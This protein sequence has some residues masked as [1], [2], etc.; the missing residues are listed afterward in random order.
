MTRPITVKHLLPLL[1]LPLFF[2]CHPESPEDLLADVRAK[3]A[4]AQSISY[5]LHEIW[6]NRFMGTADTSFSTV[7]LY[8][9]E[10][11]TWDYDYIKESESYD[12]WLIG[13]R[14]GL[15]LHDEG[16]AIVRTEE[17]TMANFQNDAPNFTISSAPDYLLGL[18]DWKFQCDTSFA[19]RM[20]KMYTYRSSFSQEDTVTYQRYEYLFIDP[21]SR[22]VVG[23]RFI[24]FINER[25]N[26]VV[27]FWYEN[28]EEDQLEPLNYVPVRNYAQTT[29]TAY[30]A[31]RT[32]G[33]IT[34]GEPAPDFVAT[35]LSGDTFALKDYR[36]QRL[37]LD[38]SFIGCGGCE[39]AMKE[40]NRPGFKLAD[41]MKGV[42]LSY[43]NKP[44]EISTHYKD[45]GMPFIAIP[46]ARDP[47][48]MY[49][50]YAYPTFVIID[51][52]GKVER[53]EVGFS[54]EFIAS[55]EER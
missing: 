34:V 16:I 4:M 11:P 10:K 27:S 28:Y 2:A 5:E 46:E 29:Q 25:T 21:E 53:V 1:F 30:D 43:M 6:D 48:R 42:Y 54:E 47:D 51:E 36:G 24:H 39:L 19:G 32:K 18:P 22:R 23:N 26:Q 9:N 52:E 3:T 17:E 45:K 15:D 49:G 50:I 33:Q 38:F 41:G 37:M 40:F 14:S 13:E 44:K 12:S 8:R 20:T 55:I 35:T 31:S 7:K